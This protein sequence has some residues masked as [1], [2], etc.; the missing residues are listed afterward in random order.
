TN[1]IGGR[2]ALL[3]ELFGGKTDLLTT[4]V[5][6]THGVLSNHGKY[7]EKDYANLVANTLMVATHVGLLTHH[8]QKSVDPSHVV[9]N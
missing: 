1:I 5:K 6:H 3:L 7:V 4:L 9:V 8:G 2:G